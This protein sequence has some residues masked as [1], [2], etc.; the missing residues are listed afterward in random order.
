[1]TEEEPTE[2]LKLTFVVPKE[3]VGLARIMAEARSYRPSLPPIDWEAERKRRRNELIEKLANLEHEQWCYWTHQLV[4][5]GRIP[6][7]LVKK[8]KANWV[9]YADLPEEVKEMDRE[10]ARRALAIVEER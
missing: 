9:R 8:W 6:D 4:S 10:W 7:W 3:M 2:D 1:M 5:A